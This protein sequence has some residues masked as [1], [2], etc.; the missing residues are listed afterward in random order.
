MSTKNQPGH[1]VQANRT[2]LEIDVGNVRVR[3]YGVALVLIAIAVASALY[4][5]VRVR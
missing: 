2:A 5:L 4:A 1:V 3:V